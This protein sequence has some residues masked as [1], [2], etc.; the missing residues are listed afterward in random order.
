MFHETCNRPPMNT[1]RPHDVAVAL[2]LVL[3]PGMTYPALSQALGLSLGEAHNAVRRLIAARLVRRDDRAVNRGALFEFL[4]AGVPYAFAAEQGPPVRGV[5][6]AHSAPSLS[7]RF[8][9]ADPVVWPSADG[10]VRGAGVEPLIATAPTF[11][12]TNERLYHLLAAVDALRIGR[13]RERQLFKDYL[14]KQLG[15]VAGVM[16]EFPPT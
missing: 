6:T 11:A 3:A 13:A 1:I 10:T 14:K 2:Q 9:S 15:G 4:T 5:P 16:S 8:S 7:E 12:R